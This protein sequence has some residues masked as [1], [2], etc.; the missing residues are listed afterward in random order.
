MIGTR[1]DTHAEIAAAALR[2]GKA[3][4]VEKPLGLTPRGDRRGLGRP[5][6]TT[7]GSRSASTGRS[8]RSPSRLASEVRAS[9]GRSTSSTA[10]TRRCRRTTGS[11]TRARAAG[12]SWARHATC[13]TSRTGCAARRSGRRGGAAGAPDGAARWRAPAI[14]IEYADGSVA[15]VH[16]SGVG[17]GVDAQ[18]AGRG[19]P[20]RALVGARRLP[21]AHLAR[22][23]RRADR[24]G[25]LRR[26]R[27]TPR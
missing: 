7:T 10:S 19:A 18:G 4:F 16:Y 5:A 26:T 27:D 21:L 6:A 1:H 15:T 24:D 14:T 25:T 17:A 22:R 2:A 8:P 12:A 9:A 20:R 13:S 23:R 3:V 11:T